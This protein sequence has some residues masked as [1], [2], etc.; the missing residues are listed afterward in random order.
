LLY[1]VCL[2]KNQ[3]CF[4]LDEPT[5]HLDAEAVSLLEKRLKSYKGTV[6]VVTHDRYFLNNVTEWILEIEHGRCIPWHANYSSWL[7][8]KE[9]EMKS[10]DKQEEDR[11][12]AN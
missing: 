8:Q 12:K 3:I 11:K 7:E 6:I 1:A 2:W 4:L 10:N 9:K 5:N